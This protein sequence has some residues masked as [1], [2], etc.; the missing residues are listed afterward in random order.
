MMIKNGDTT[1]ETYKLID[2]DNTLYGYRWATYRKTE[3]LTNL[4][5]F[6]LGLLLYSPDD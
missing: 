2:Y 4:K 3:S 6:R 5:S 1:G